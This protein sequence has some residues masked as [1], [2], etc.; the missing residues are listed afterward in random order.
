MLALE[1]SAY[2]VLYV[3]RHRSVTAVVAVSCADGWWLIWGRASA[4]AACDVAAAA[5]ALTATAAPPAA[6]APSSSTGISTVGRRPVRRV[7]S[8]S[9]NLV[10]RERERLGVA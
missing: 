5:D 1:G 10:T 9:A 6:P 2:P 3:Q 8:R 4:V 7:P